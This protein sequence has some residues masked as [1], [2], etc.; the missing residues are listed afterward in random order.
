MRS[1][2]PAGE[3]TLMLAERNVC[4]PERG[5]LRIV[6]LSSVTGSSSS[7]IGGKMSFMVFAEPRLDRLPF[8]VPPLTCFLMS[9]KDLMTL[10]SLV[11][12]VEVR[13]FDTRL[14]FR[15]AITAPSRRIIL[16]NMNVSHS[17]GAA[18]YLSVGFAVPSLYASG[19]GVKTQG[20]L[21]PAGSRETG[22]AVAAI[23]LTTHG[24]P[25]P[26]GPESRTGI[27]PRFT[28]GCNIPAGVGGYSWYSAV[29][30]LA[31]AIPSGTRPCA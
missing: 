14:L 5:G 27:C 24:I 13:R 30:V 20:I 26:A 28:A 3:R 9:T 6:G 22:A 10:V 25:G 19:P 7:Y 31:P 16:W 1:V 15:A 11:L 8:V 21:G 17:C 23:G 18:A 29:L 12:T 4:I 2:C